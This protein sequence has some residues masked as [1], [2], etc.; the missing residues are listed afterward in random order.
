M[1]KHGARPTKIDHRDYDFTKS[2]G[3]FKTVPFPAEYNTD[4]G[5]TMPDQDAQNNYFNPPVP[6]LPYGCT[7]Y[8]T[9]EVATDLD[10]TFGANNPMKVEN[11]TQAN[12]R[13]GYDIRQSLLVGV[14]LGFFSGIFNVRA[15]GQDYFDA[16]RTAM[17]SGGTER[18]SVSIGTPWYP[19]FELVGQDGI[20]GIPQSF[21]TAGL[22]WHNW[23]VCGWKTIGSQVYLVAKTWQGP[24]YGDHGLVYFS[25][26]L[27][28]NLMAIPGTV[29]F[30][31]TTGVLP[32]ISTISVTWLQW[33]ISYARNLLPY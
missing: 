21:S 16:I 27:I 26:P 19:K 3:S 33:I 22:P 28:N 2:F 23:K 5:L 31:A 8:A 4:A 6:A 32:P 7:D 20:V 17:V 9:A 1:I 14:S 24:N 11:V 25:R 18:R 15:I 29:A 13:G 12:A 30:T 10:H